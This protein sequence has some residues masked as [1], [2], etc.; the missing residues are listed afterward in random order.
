MN[1]IVRA[2][3]PVSQLPEDLRQGLDPAAEVTVIIEDA[4]PPQQPMTIA[5]IFAARQPPYRSAQEIDQQII[6]QRDGWND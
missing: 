5:Q 2:H 1:K 3:Y 4:E 6:E